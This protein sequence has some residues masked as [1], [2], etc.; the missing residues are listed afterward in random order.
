MTLE[1][2]MGSEPPED[3][4]RRSPWSRRSDSDQRTRPDREGAEGPAP[5]QDG[6]PYAAEDD[7]A[8][9]RM[10]GCAMIVGIAV[11]AGLLVLIF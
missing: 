7:R 11:I 1:I 8:L 6:P 3:P 9:A 5:N 4:S 2:V 10:L